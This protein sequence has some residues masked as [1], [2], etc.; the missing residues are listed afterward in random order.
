VKG[1][2]ENRRGLS[3]RDLEDQ[4][5]NLLQDIDRINNT[6]IDINKTRDSPTLL[7]AKTC[8]KSSKKW[9][10]RKTKQRTVVQFRHNKLRDG[11][12]PNT[13]L[14]VIWFNLISK[15]ITRIVAKR[16]L[17]A[18]PEEGESSDPEL[19]DERP[20]EETTETSSDNDSD[21]GDFKRRSRR[22]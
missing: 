4:Q 16:S 10:R 2:P 9:N 6:I 5:K 12:H 3:R 13:E 18:I 11:L 15:F 8:L 7:L 21:H 22:K 19:D 17:S 14:K 1:A 20:K